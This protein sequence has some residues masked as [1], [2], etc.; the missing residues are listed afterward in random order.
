MKMMPTPMSPA[1]T[2]AT[3]VSM[4]RI[5][6]RW[7]RRPWFL[8]A[9]VVV[10][11]IDLASTRCLALL[12]CGHVRH[13]RA[14][15]TCTR[16]PAP[17][18]HHRRTRT[19]RDRRLGGG[20]NAAAGRTR[21]VQPAGALQPLQRQGRHRARRRHRRLHRTRR[22]PAP[23]PPHRPRAGPGPARRLPRLSDVRDRAPRAVPGHVRPA[24][25]PEVREH[26]DTAPAT[27]LLRRV[28]QLL[29]PANKRRELFAEVTW[30]ALHG[31]AVL[32]AS[33]RIPSDG[34]EER[35]DFL[36]TQIAGTHTAFASGHSS[37]P[38]AV[39]PTG[40][41]SGPNPGATGTS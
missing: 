10:A 19:R 39:P 34:Q 17:T 8:A 13:Q 30:S 41:A 32:S 36:I 24:H 25:R 26:R 11:T 9:L 6:S 20:D 33:H 1:S 4:G 3:L 37:A 40:A 27:G 28:R 16:P 5:P 38:V 7:Q 15:R 12:E 23:R 35:L 21:R 29:P 14:P 18:D 22:P 2:L 31:M